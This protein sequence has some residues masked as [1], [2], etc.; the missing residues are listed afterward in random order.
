M[1]ICIQIQQFHTNGSNF[2][3]LKFSEGVSQKQKT[4]NV[5]QRDLE[6]CSREMAEGTD[7]TLKH[8]KLA[9]DLTEKKVTLTQQSIL[10]NY[11]Q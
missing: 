11:F 8:T 7:P 6:K 10:K 1:C 2:K 5:E 4:T 3:L 9:G